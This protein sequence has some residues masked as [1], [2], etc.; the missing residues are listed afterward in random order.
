MKSRNPAPRLKQRMSSYKRTAVG[1][2]LDQSHPSKPLSLPIPQ[3]KFEDPTFIPRLSF[4]HIPRLRTDVRSLIDYLPQHTDHALF[5]DTNLTWLEEEWWESLL[6]EAGRVHV[7]G[8]VLRELVPFLQR[9][10]EHPLCAALAAND[11]AIVLCPD[12][13]DDVWSRCFDYYVGILT[14]RRLLLDSSIKHF[15]AHHNARAPSP[16]ELTELKMKIQSAFGERTL[17]LNLKPLSPIRTDEALVFQAVHHAVTT[18]QPTKIFSGD[19]DVEEQFYMMVRILTAHYYEL[20]LGRRY[21]ADFTSFNPRSIPQPVMAAYDRMYETYGAAMIDLDGKGIHDFIP[22]HTTFV[23]VSCVT[24]GK[25]YT[26]ELTY[27]AETSMGEVFTTKAR[28]LGLSTDQLA[29]RDVHPWLIP[30]DLQTI[31]E[32]DA[33][34]AFDK[35]RLTLP[36]SGMRISQHDFGLTV[37]RGDPH[38]RVGE[39]NAPLAQPSRVVVP[40][41]R[42]RRIIAMRARRPVEHLELP[43]QD[44]AA[45]LNATR[46]RKRQRERP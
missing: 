8:R 20:I 46:A 36:K 10:P 6:S 34:V 1:R 24:L 27:G 42:D 4:R 21:A 35:A 22:R 14:H 40:S 37:W 31:G 16:A 30:K 44:R 19:L 11:P 18:G 9:N 3:E 17:R 26:S 5:I 33:L 39:P 23:P 45:A 32:H 28:T 7:T 38:A 25:Q 13:D 29:G 2:L 43:Q 15:Q 41:D 12:I